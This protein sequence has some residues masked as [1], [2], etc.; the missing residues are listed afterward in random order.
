MRVVLGIFTAG[1]LIIALALSI[2]VARDQAR[3][4]TPATSATVAPARCGSADGPVTLALP[5]AA[6]AERVE[7]AWARVENWLVSNAPA[8]AAAWN[9]PAT[10]AEL[11]T[12]QR[13]L[14]SPLPSELVITLTRHNGARA[15]GFTLPPS[16]R[17]MSA[18]EILTTAVAMCEE[19]TDWRAGDVPFAK[20]DKGVI[21]LRGGGLYR[22]PTGHRYAGNLVELVERAADRLEGG[23][24][25]DYRP[26]V[27]ALGTLR[28]VHE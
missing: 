26:D 8:T 21:Y 27:D 15:D 23:S 12:L 18:G 11:I 7:G 28:W 9:R 25:S 16:Y 2:G 4:P 20:D 14:G 19:G 13:D 10:T 3:P 22:Y 24:E 17:L 1:G 5:P 6:F